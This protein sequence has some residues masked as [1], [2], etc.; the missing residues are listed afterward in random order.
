MFKKREY[1]IEIAKKLVK[2]SLFFAFV[3]HCARQEKKE[4]CDITSFSPYQQ[5]LNYWNP[6]EVEIV[7]NRV[8]NRAKFDN[9][10]HQKLID[11]FNAIQDRRKYYYDNCIFGEGIF[12][13]V[14]RV[15]VYALSF[16]KIHVTK[17]F[18]V[19]NKEDNIYN[20]L[21]PK[22]S[23]NSSYSFDNSI[24]NDEE[25]MRSH[26]TE[27]IAEMKRELEEV[28]TLIKNTSPVKKFLARI[29]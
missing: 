23:Y 21:A 29:I 25:T 26:V 12:G 1:I 3:V 11:L 16:G 15:G 10:Y 18:R 17:G 5:M 13:I 27:K 9:E 7:N 4:N 2:M 24:Y 22:F 6:H 14:A 8:N 19:Y 28:N 20:I